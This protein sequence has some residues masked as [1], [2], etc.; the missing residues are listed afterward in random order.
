METVIRVKTGK[1]YDV[2]IGSGVISSVPDKIREVASG[3]KAAIVTDDIVNGLYAEHLEKLLSDAGI[4]FCKFVF[5]NGEKNKNTAT[6]ISL[7]EFLSAE[8]LSRTD[9]VI[10]LGGG[11]VGDT[12]GFAAATYL[13]G[14]KYIQIPTTVLAAVDSSVGGKCAVDLPAGKN[15]VGAFHQPSAVICDIDTFDTLPDKIF[16]DGCGE[17]LKYGIL[18]S[19]RLFEMIS[20]HGCDFPKSEVV[21]ECVKIKADIVSRDEFDRGCRALLNLGHT[22]AHAIERLSGYSVSHGAAVST[23]CA[24]AAAASA[25]YGI[26]SHEVALKIRLAVEKLGYSAKTEYTVDELVSVMMSDKKRH[27]DM[28][29]FIVVSDIGACDIRAFSADELKAFVSSGIKAL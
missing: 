27:G 11:V 3:A 9:V 15:L 14:I 8:G 24:I 12:A 29:D 10:A 7:L 17:I 1:P 2:T 23:G 16:S 4:E 6:Y 25:S 21:A 5:P 28:T 20:E 22:C 19:P 13:R 18:A 26:C